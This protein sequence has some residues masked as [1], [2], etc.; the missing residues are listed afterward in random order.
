MANSNNMVV[1][2]TCH[3]GTE[4]LIE[5]TDTSRD[6]ES[7]T[8]MWSDIYLKRVEIILKQMDKV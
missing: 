7:H 8:L 5:S 2:N 1:S 6:M 4:T 3:S